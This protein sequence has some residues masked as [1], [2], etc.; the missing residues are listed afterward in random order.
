[1]DSPD[2]CPLARHVRGWS[3]VKGMNKRPCSFGISPGPLSRMYQSLTLR[4]VSFRSKACAGAR[5]G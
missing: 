5:Y 2:P 4:A 1:M 3:R